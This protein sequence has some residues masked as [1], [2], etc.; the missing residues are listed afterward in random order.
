MNGNG[1]KNGRGHHRVQ[2]RHWIDTKYCVDVFL[3]D[4]SGMKELGDDNEDEPFA[5]SGLWL[6]KFDERP[7]IGHVYILATLSLAEK[8][9]TWRHELVHV[10]NDFNNAK[11]ERIL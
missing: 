8:W 2:K 10:L 6:S 11:D 1:K 5:A 9:K 4:A 7:C 3:V